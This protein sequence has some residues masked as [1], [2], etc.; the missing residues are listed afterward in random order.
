MIAAKGLD[1][2]R[3]GHVRDSMVE[4]IKIV[5]GFY[6]CEKASP[7]RGGPAAAGP[8]A[9]AATRRPAATA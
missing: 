8:T 4:L 1:P 6:A 3:H 5:E 9:T 2:D 7:S